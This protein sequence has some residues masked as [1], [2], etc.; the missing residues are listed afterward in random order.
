MSSEERIAGL[1]RAYG[2]LQG[3]NKILN[4]RIATLQTAMIHTAL[5]AAAK[6]VGVRAEALDD[7]LLRDK[8]FEVAADGVVAA[9]ENVGVTPGVSPEQ[10]LQEVRLRN[11]HW[12]SSQSHAGPESFDKNPW[13]REFWNVTAQGRIIDSNYQQAEAMSRAAGV[14]VMAAHPRKA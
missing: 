7:V 3:E 6:A 1:E 5:R 10:W 13:S 2:N 12:F 8:I 14:D 4:A 9:K 11:P